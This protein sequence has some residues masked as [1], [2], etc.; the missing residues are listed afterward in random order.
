MVDYNLFVALTHSAPSKFNSKLVLSP[1][2][3]GLTLRHGFLYETFTMVYLWLILIEYM[4]FFLFLMN[5]PKN[6]WNPLFSQFGF[7]SVDIVVYLLN[8]VYN[9]Y[10]LCDNMI[11]VL[12]SMYNWL[13]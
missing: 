12:L 13:I 10:W 1:K 4:S 2:L 3:K 9:D 7:S 11:L 6:P 8:C 5:H